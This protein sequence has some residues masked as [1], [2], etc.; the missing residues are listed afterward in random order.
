MVT[1]KQLRYFVALADLRHFGRAAERCNVSQPALSMQIRELEATLGTTLVE[2]MPGG[3]L[4]TAA[5][6]QTAAR[7]RDILLAVQELE[8][9]G[10][11]SG[12]PWS[13]RLRLGVIPTVGPY[14]LPQILPQL[15]MRHPGLK[16]TLRESQTHL[17]LADLLAGKLDLLILALP[18][19]REDV[20]TM[21]LF[22]DVFTLAVPP[23]HRL[24]NRSTVHQDELIGEYVLLLEEG[25]CLRDQALSLCHAAGA[26]E[27]D[28]FRAS[29]LAT[30]VQM[31]MNGYGAT[32][33]PELALPVEVGERSA[34]RIIPF[35]DPPP[36]RTIG[37]AWRKSAPRQADFRAFGELVIDVLRSRTDD[38]M[39][40]I[41]APAAARRAMPRKAVRSRPSLSRRDPEGTP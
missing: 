22:E 4:L 17:L 1:L 15:H 16:L 6:E 26:T 5:G 11:Q 32:I 27:M 29:S 14:L 40:R 2:R 33:L 28:D 31:V 10:A 35:V 21:P 36:A 23:D 9:G 8:Q 34:L 20:L 13:G 39:V 38:H 7:A 19:G 3:V 30:V 25:H 37:L 18:V 24:A 41:P 12:D